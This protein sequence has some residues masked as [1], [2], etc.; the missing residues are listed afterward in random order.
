MYVCIAL[1]RRSRGTGR[2]WSGWGGGAGRRGR[3]GGAGGGDA[4]PKIV[5][6]DPAAVAADGF[7]VKKAFPFRPRHFFAD[8][9]A[10]EAALGWR[11]RA[12]A[13]DDLAAVVAASY[14]EYVALG[15]GERDVSFALDDMILDAGAVAA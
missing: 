7:S 1:Y 14:A 13:A 2:G 15:C 12:A 4:P 3:G 5:H 10:A 8:A 9:G 6:Y 11:A